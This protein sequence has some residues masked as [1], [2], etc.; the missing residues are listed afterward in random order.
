M[1]AITTP[2]NVVVVG[3]GQAGIQLVDSLRKEGYTGA[4]TLIGEETHHPYQRP[5]LSKDYLAAGKDPVPLPL[6]PEKF[7]TT[8]DVDARLGVRVTSIDRT[9]RTATLDD[10]TTLAYSTLVLATGAANR[11]L[12]VPGADLAGIHGLRTLTDAQA[13]HARLDTV[14][15]VVVIGAGFIGLEFAAAA[16][17]RGLDVT[18]LEYADRP[19]GRALTP[20]M[21]GFF[22]DAHGRLG[23]TL[24]LGEGIASFDGDNGHVTAAVST[25]GHRYPTD[26]VLVGVGVTPRTELAAAA[27]LDVDNGIV[28]DGSLRTSDPNIYA[29]GD[30]ASFP[31]THAG[32]RTR[33]ESVQNA[34]DQARHAAA[35]IL[36]SR[37]GKEPGS[38]TGVE[39]GSMPGSEPAGGT[40]AELGGYADLPWFWS[41]QGPLRL[42][43]AGLVAPGDQTVL[44]GNPAEEKFSVFCFRNGTLTAVESVNQPADHMAARRLLAAGLPLTPEQ[45]ADPDF[46]LKAYSKQQPATV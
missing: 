12:A 4:I 9:A 28:V 13:L 6:R 40:G 22:A 33:L 14:R 30:C 15:S 46:D 17:A 11:E 18:V 29:L 2:D 43:I 16:R 39:S 31:N 24:R 27:G 25:T 26:L 37:P 34:T 10:G 44:R 5:P 8:H 3:N 7:F 36:A 32:T 20:V 35:A 41:N 1:N 21:S 23:V 19:M 45:A 42:Q 38:G